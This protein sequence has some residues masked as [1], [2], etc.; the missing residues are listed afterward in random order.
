MLG[1]S[2][3]LNHIRLEVETALFPEHL[4][5]RITSRMDKDLWI[6]LKFLLLRIAPCRL[7]G[8]DT[9][10]IAK[11]LQENSE[12]VEVT[13]DLKRVRPS[14]AFTSSLILD[15]VVEETHP[16]QI[17]SLFFGEGILHDCHGNQLEASQMYSPSCI[18]FHQ[19]T[20]SSWR[21]IFDNSLEAQNALN[22]ILQKHQGPRPII[23]G[24]Y[25]ERKLYPIT[26][27]RQITRPPR[28]LFSCPASP[29]SIDTQIFT[30]Q[31]KNRG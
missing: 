16:S 5:P 12:L 15:G 7:W 4:N 14:W 1:S 24:I 23:A 19:M 31:Y 26:S 29:T 9:A 11:H 10:V 27:S 28:Q 8:E 18:G 25:V 6:S 21:V 30:T 2:K 3:S 13:P 22:V 17:A 20:A